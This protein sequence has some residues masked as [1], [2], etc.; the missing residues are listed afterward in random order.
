MVWVGLMVG[1]VVLA[2]VVVALTRGR[3]GYKQ[4]EEPDAVT[5]AT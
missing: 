1:F 3:L 2:L 5:A 4:E